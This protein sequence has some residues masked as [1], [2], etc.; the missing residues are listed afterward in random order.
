MKPQTPR[1]QTRFFPMSANK[2]LIGIVT[3]IYS[4]FVIQHPE[5]VAKTPPVSATMQ[6]V[7]NLA[8]QYFL[9]Y[10]LIFICSSIKTV[11]MGQLGTFPGKP[12]PLI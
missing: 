2:C 11:A 9:I 5:G 3:V 6:C 8:T 12:F 7:I 1:P 4:V 10:T